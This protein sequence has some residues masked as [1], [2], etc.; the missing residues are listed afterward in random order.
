MHFPFSHHSIMHLTISEILRDFFVF[1]IYCVPALSLHIESTD[2]IILFVMSMS[3]GDWFCM[4]R[5]GGGENGVTVSVLGFAPIGPRKQLSYLVGPQCN[6]Q[7]QF[8]TYSRLGLP[9]P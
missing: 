4:G 3:L 1:I 5:K 2:S 7:G 6:V 8:I 9:E